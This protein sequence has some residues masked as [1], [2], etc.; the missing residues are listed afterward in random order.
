MKRILII[1]V[2]IL[3]SPV[4]RSVDAQNAAKDDGS[5]YPAEELTVQ[6]TNQCAFAGEVLW[7]KIYCTSPLFPATELSRLAYI[8]LVNSDNASLIRK[9]ILLTDGNGKGEFV[10]PVDLPSGVYYVIAYTNW[11]K[12]FGEEHFFRKAIAIINPDQNFTLPIAD[13]MAEVA[14]KSVPAEIS[15]GS[16]GNPLN[17]HPDKQTYGTRETVKLNLE[18]GLTAAKAA[19]GHYS[20]VVSKK[21]PELIA[22]DG[23]S[24]SDNPATAD[25][26]QY[27]PDYLGVKLSGN[28]TDVSGDPVA[29]KQVILSYPGPG[30][31]VK[32]VITDSTGDFNFLLKPGEDDIDVVFT[33]PGTDLRMNLKESFWNGFRNPPSGASLLLDSAGVKFLKERYALIQL[34]RRFKQ[35]DF[36]RIVENGATTKNG[37]WQFYTNSDEL[38]KASDYIRL[39]SITEYFWELLPSARFSQKKGKFDIEVI[40]PATT[41][42]FEDPPGV[43]VDG[44]LYTDFQQIA[45]MSVDALREIGVISHIYYY[46]DFTFGGIVDIHTKD[47][48]FSDVALQPNMVRVRYPLGAKEEMTYTLPSFA[49][50]GK[51]TRVPDLRYL[52][53]WNPEVDLPEN[54]ENATVSFTTSDIEGD[55]TISVIGITGDGKIIHS[56]SGFTVKSDGGI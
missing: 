13:T 11:M 26:M 3:I 24:T 56:E 25:K 14:T 44:V 45:T 43:F 50:A 4:W 38:I 32:D 28:I 12:N 39:D 22:G 9:K 36:K 42:T 6:L 52:L 5:K 18:S 48:N 20:I 10:I 51:L 35:Q 1:A 53:Y 17:I 8:E 7:F 30:T 15:T 31:D 2:L 37:S 16:P 27:L 23:R 34:Q 55:Y 21:Q 49:D 41:T 19:G 29:G 46:R 54:G 40:N 33:L 47:N